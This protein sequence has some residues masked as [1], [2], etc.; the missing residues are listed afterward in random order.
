[1]TGRENIYLN[2]AILGMTKKEITSKIDEII[3][4]SGCQRYI[5]TPVKRYSSRMTVPLGFAVVANLLSKKRLSYSILR[6]FVAMSYNFR[7]FLL[8]ES[9]LDTAKLTFIK[10]I[11]WRFF[12][13]VLPLRLILHKL[14]R[15][16]SKKKCKLF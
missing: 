4:F 14:K 11:Y 2:G 16:I 10:K 3:E 8:F 6:Y 5:D 13:F 1:M 15:K 7:E 12:F 9:I